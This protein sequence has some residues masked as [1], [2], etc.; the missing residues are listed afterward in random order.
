MNKTIVIALGA[1]A[2]VAVGLVAFRD[3][4]GLTG[5][6]PASISLNSAQAQGTAPAAAQPSLA[7]AAKLQPDDRVLGN[8]D[9]PVMILEYASFTCPHCAAFN[10][11]VMPKVKADWIDT[12]KAKLVFRDFPLDK[13]ALRGAVLA[14]CAPPERFFGF[15]D[16]LFRQQ[17][18]WATDKNPDAALARIGKLGG[19]TQEQV[20]ACFADKEL[21]NKVLA[22]RLTGDQV[23]KVDATP[24]LFVA[25]KRVSNSLEAMEQALKQASGS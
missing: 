24:T 4:L 5:S 14:R 1:V 10:A 20:D 2:V 9:A 8:R 18:S 11:E 3:Q 23:L 6:V 16:V 25:G 7:D 17:N 15:V 19:L 21:E 22:Q 12:G 13:Y